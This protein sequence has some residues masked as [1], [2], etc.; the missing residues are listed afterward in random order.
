MNKKLTKT[1]ILIVFVVFLGIKNVYAEKT[2]IYRLG[3][4]KKISVV[5]DDSGGVQANYENNKI[6]E[7]KNWSS[8]SASSKYASNVGFYGYDYYKNNDTKCPPGV[9]LA[10]YA[11]ANDL[12]FTSDDQTT[13]DN[14][15]K[16][17][18]GQSGFLLGGFH[19]N[20]NFELTQDTVTSNPSNTNSNSNS[21]SDDSADDGADNGAD[22]GA[23]AESPEEFDDPSINVNVGSLNQNLDTFSCGDNFVTGIPRRLL[24]VT[25]FLYSFLQFLV[26]IA[27]I[28]L[29]ILDLLKAISSQKED[30]I[31]KGQQTLVK[32]IVGAAVVFFVFAIVKLIVSIASSENQRIISCV[33]CFLNFTRS[34]SCQK[35]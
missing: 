21:S 23:D 13:N 6:S 4:D 1:I 19:S 14:I 10:N 16:Y 20:E 24:L 22:D 15:A 33:D 32:R 17:A 34:S 7:I 2:C 35:E 12:Y 31:K 27:L 11:T 29:G 18:D 3:D 25:R 28:V 5:I 8:D 30:E 26:P 9:L